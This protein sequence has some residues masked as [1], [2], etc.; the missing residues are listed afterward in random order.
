MLHHLGF[1]VPESHHILSLCDTVGALDLA[2][3]IERGPGR[4]GVSNA[5]YVYLRD[6]DG[7]RVEIYT[8]D[9]FTGDPGHEPLRWNVRDERRRDFWA[10]PVV[11]GWYLGSAPVLDLDGRAVPVVDQEPTERTVTVGADG[12]D[13]VVHDRVPDGV[14]EAADA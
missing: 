13:T 6:P 5:F 1:A 8:S 7:H 12:F 11:P 10:N 3:H 2:H 14:H 4:H 9:Y